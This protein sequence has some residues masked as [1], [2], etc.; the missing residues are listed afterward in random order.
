MNLVSLNSKCETERPTGIF[1]LREKNSLNLYA[2][3]LFEFI[4]WIFLALS[5]LALF[6]TEKKNK[7][8]E[9]KTDAMYELY[10][11]QTLRPYLEI[12]VKARKPHI[13]RI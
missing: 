4:E 7:H 6:V 10:R 13:V 9:N 11:S 8:E 3:K 12:Y 2:R 1:F 5:Y